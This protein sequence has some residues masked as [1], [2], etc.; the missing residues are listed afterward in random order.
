MAEVDRRTQNR[1]IGS[2]LVRSGLEWVQSCSEILVAVV[3]EPQFY[4]RFGFN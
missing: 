4:G 1:G 2:S 3:G